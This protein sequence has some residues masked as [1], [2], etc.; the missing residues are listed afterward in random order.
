MP[1]GCSVLVSLVLL[2]SLIPLAPGRAATSCDTDQVYAAFKGIDS[3]G[4]KTVQQELMLIGHDQVEWVD[5]ILG[6]RTIRALMRF[7]RDL[8]VDDYQGLPATELVALTR[9]AD[10]AQHDP[11]WREV[12]ANPDFARW[13]GQQSSERQIYFKAIQ[14]AGGV[15]PITIL[16]DYR[17]AT[18]PSAPPAETSVPPQ[19]DSAVYYRLSAEDLAELQAQGSILQQLETLKDKAYPNAYALKNAV[20]KTLGELTRL[21]SEYAEIAL[22]AAQQSLSYRLTAQSFDRLRIDNIP[23]A[24]LKPLQEIKDLPYPSRAKLEN[25]VMIRLEQAAEAQAAAT[26]AP[27]PPEPAAQAD[28]EPQTQ[29]AEQTS[30]KDAAE[31]QAQAEN[32]SHTENPSQTEDQG[33][34]DAEPQNPARE[35]A[36]AK[37]QL[38]PKDAAE[39]PAQA[40]APEQTATPEQADAADQPAPQAQAVTDLTEFVPQISAQAEQIKVYQLTDAS[41]KQLGQRPDLQAIPAA[42]LSM[43]GKLQDVEYI[44][45]ALFVQALHATLDIQIGQYQKLIIQEAG[46]A[47]QITPQSLDNLKAKAV[48][49]YI[50]EAVKPLQSGFYADQSAFDQAVQDALHQLT[51]GFKEDRLDKVFVQQARRIAPER[52]GT[53]PIRWDGGSCGCSHKLS[54]VVYG[55]YPFWLA[56]QVQIPEG[57]DPADAKQL[58]DFSLLSRVGYYGVYL[59]EGGGISQPRHWRNDRNDLGFVKTLEKYRPDLDLVVYT[60]AWQTWTETQ[61]NKAATAVADELALPL[62]AT[63][64]SRLTG[65]LPFGPT[66]APT[67]GDGVT[68]YFDDFTNPAKAELRKNISSFLQKLWQ[69]LQANPKRLG[70]NVMIGIRWDELGEQSAIFGELSSLLIEQDNA[71]LGIDLLLVLLEEPTTNTKKMLRSKIENEFKGLNRK[72]VLRK[73]IPI[74]SPAGHDKELPKPYAQF[75]DDL[76]YFEDNFKGVGLWPLPLT[77]APDAAKINA[78]I[79]NYFEPQQK[80]DV[81]ERLVDQY[82]P[83]LCNYACPNRWQFRIL[84]DILVV[85]LILLALVAQSNCRLR[86]WLKHYPWPALALLVATIL[87]FAVSLVCDPF[88]KQRSD[89]V[90]IGLVVALVIIGITR[91][92][93]KI[94]Q[95][96]LP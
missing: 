55:F 58:V 12:V 82:L 25:A 37:D 7:C 89:D 92:I 6:P 22:K 74:V 81:M 11:D 15:L 71:K 96:P 59:D 90:A 84:F 23:D 62:P 86:E 16:A 87:V 50:L 33:Q 66:A 13:L 26:P 19:D 61:I 20:T 53:I 65:W 27:A 29:S 44:D 41:F 48:P 10:F 79:A 80:P 88:W 45:Q 69:A 14:T 54:R 1:K 32:P 67:L 75:T 56:D 47:W 94:N 17:A 35:Q 21:S 51:A 91:Y 30:A 72:N 57:T 31:T 42:L 64:R 46:K 77:Q 49:D 76:I 3:E 73:I 24:A 8:A 4:I 18:A 36:D 93:R 9:Y 39:G 34:A 60:N 78:L 40:E 70:L 2:L 83:Q 28:P 95:G 85:A 5:G 43:I 52:L 38:K 63:T 68:V